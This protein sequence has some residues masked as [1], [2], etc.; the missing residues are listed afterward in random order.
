MDYF[1]FM[2]PTQNRTCFCYR[3]MFLENM[4]LL[5]SVL[6]LLCFSRM[7]SSTH[8]THVLQGSQDSRIGSDKTRDETNHARP[9]CLPYRFQAIVASL[10]NFSDRRKAV[11][12][13]SRDWNNRIQIH[14]SVLFDSGGQEQIIRQTF[15]DFKHMVQ[16]EY[17]PG[18]SCHTST[19][20][21][22]MLEPCMPE[23]ASYLGQSYMGA[24]N[25]QM[26]VNTWNFQRT[27]LNRDLEITIVVTADKCVPVSE[28]ITGKIGTGK[29]E[30][31][32][33]FT[34]VTEQ[35]DNSVFEIPHTC[36]GVQPM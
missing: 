18:G 32:I 35:V 24:Y 21:Y 26:V 10:P 23:N 16:Y 3:S 9:C 31:M 4:L 17:T 2:L 30:S 22:G 15:M 29:A 7:V 13:M 11:A 1:M 20:N 6:S 36:F 19:L 12:R 25:N 34:N 5:S 28:H 33:F 8:R 27:N 14:S